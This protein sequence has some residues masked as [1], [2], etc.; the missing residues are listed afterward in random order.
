M[1]FKAGFEVFCET[2]VK[3]L[4]GFN[5]LENVDVI[6][7]HRVIRYGVVGRKNTYEC[8]RPERG[9]MGVDRRYQIRPSIF[10]I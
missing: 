8:C 9:D 4:G 7:S 1:G 10:T 3:V 6:E 2:C 5:G